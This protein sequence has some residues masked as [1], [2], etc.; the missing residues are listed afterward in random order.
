MAD[1]VKIRRGPAKISRK[2]DRHS[3]WRYKPPV[4][5][6]AGYFRCCGNKQTL[7]V[8][9]NKTFGINFRNCDFR[10]GTAHFSFKQTSWSILFR[11]TGCEKCEMI[12]GGSPLE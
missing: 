11:R 2:I 12:T 8:N 5:A 7:A 4:G 10:H 1:K 9:P 6:G 3:P